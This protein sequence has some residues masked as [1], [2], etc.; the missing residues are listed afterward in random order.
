MRPR[1]RGV[2]G[3]ALE[4][5]LRGLAGGVVR[6]VSIQAV[7]VGLGH[8]LLKSRVQQGPRKFR[9]RKLSGCPYIQS[10]D[11]LQNLNDSFKYLRK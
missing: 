9:T 3:D 6:H 8:L 2:G 1:Q 11:L 4:E 10:S 7:A 5:R